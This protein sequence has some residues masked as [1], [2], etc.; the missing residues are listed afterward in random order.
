MASAYLG[1]ECP[2]RGLEILRAGE[3]RASDQVRAWSAI[4]ESLLAADRLEDAAKVAREMPASDA[5]IKLSASLAARL[6]R[7]SRLREAEEMI[8]EVLGAGTGATG[9]LA[10]LDR[11][12]V[13]FAGFALADQSSFLARPVSVEQRQILTKLFGGR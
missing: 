7:A 12:L 9:S 4:G 1:V 5:R 2:E 10:G 3:T 8:T 11:L 13:A 6:E